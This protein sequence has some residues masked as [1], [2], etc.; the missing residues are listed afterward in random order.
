MSSSRNATYMPHSLSVSDTVTVSTGSTI[1]V[2]RATYSEGMEPDP[3]VVIIRHGKT[4]NNKLGIFTGASLH[5]FPH[6]V[7]IVPFQR[8]LRTL[9]LIFPPLYCT[10]GWQDVALAAEGRAEAAAAGK[11]LQKHGYTF[12]VVYTRYEHLMFYY[13]PSTDLLITY[14]KMMRCFS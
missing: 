6:L 2:P 5:C 1:P 8:H 3:V 7:V 4:E 9:V 12:D 13:S 14:R 11:L 10:S